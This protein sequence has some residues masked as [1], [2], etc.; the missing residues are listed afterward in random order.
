MA[1]FVSRYGA[2]SHGVREEVAEYFATGR[3]VLQKGLQAQFVSAGLTDDEA[4]YALEVLQFHGLPEDRDTGSNVSGRSRLSVFDS[5][6]Y[7]KEHKL[8]DEESELI[9]TTLRESDRIGLDYVEITPQPAALPWNGYDKLTDPAMIVELTVATETAVADVLAYELENQNRDKVVS[10][11]EEIL[12][13]S[14]DEE[15]AVVIDASGV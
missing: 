7:A 11:L 8:T 10:A 15:D 6:R 3:R 14:T 12:E 5:E 2:Y 1:R 13:E 9:V 4:R